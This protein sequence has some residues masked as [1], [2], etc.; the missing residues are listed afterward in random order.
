M[1]FSADGQ[2]IYFSSNRVKEPYYEPDD[3][4]LYS[5]AVAGGSIDT[6]LSKG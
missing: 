5:V 4:D 2:R 6:S 1:T 3:Q